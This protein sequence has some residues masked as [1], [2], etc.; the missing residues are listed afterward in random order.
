MFLKRENPKPDRI[1]EAVRAVGKRGELGVAEIQAAVVA[2]LG[3]KVISTPGGTPDLEVNAVHVEARLPWWRRILSE[4]GW[5]DDVAYFN[6]HI[7]PTLANEARL[8]TKE[9]TE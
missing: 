2:K 3:L 1:I 7:S 5:M 9:G 8:R 6:R 4:L